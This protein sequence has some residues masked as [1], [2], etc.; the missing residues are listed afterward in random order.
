MRSKK[1]LPQLQHYYAKLHS[2]NYMKK[3][4]KPK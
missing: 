4:Q 2:E 1:R 3:V